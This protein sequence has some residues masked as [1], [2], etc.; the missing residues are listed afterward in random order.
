MLT[1]CHLSCS[2]PIRLSS[3]MTQWG[4]PF[5]NQVASYLTWMCIH[6][7]QIQRENAYH[8]EAGKIYD[9]FISMLACILG[10]EFWGNKEK[11]ML[12]SLS[13]SLPWW[14][15]FHHA[16]FRS[17]CMAMQ[18]TN[19]LFHANS[20][21]VPIMRYICTSVHRLCVCLPNAVQG[22]S[23]VDLAKVGV[24]IL[25]SGS[26]LWREISIFMW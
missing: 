15:I 11:E 25:D 2:Q 10:L 6:V 13:N 14:P 5:K 9:W 17:N 21:N 22:I 19:M 3:G 7:L 20:K 23:Q 4:L 1:C 8:K 26:L 12:T 24:S 16:M 18:T